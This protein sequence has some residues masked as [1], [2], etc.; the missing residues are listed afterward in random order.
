MRC[1]AITKKGQRCRNNGVNDGLCKWHHPCT[2]KCGALTRSGRSCQIPAGLCK[3]HKRDL[4]TDP[5]LFRKYGLRNDMAVSVRDY[6]NGVDAFTREKVEDLLPIFSVVNKSVELDHVLECQ[7]FRDNFDRIKKQGVHFAD[8]K[9]ELEHALRTNVVNEL[10]NLNFTTKK[11]NED[12]GNAI[13]EFQNSFLDEKNETAQ[14]LAGFLLQE[15]SL[16]RVSARA[17]TKHIQFE[18][19]KSWEAVDDVLELDQPLQETFSDLLH[20]NIVAMK[21]K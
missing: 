16:P 10:T 7:V 9:K 11:I 17:T 3:F 19:Y 13:R 20:K 14:G 5:S 4:G 21:L 15:C 1:S 2:P 6:R 12:K 18:I 8:R